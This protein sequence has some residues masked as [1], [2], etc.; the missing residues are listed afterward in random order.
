[1]TL[2]NRMQVVN[3][4][5][6]KQKPAEMLSFKSPFVIANNENMYTGNRMRENNQT[7]VSK[8]N[9][10]SKTRKVLNEMLGK[11]GPQSTKHSNNMHVTIRT[12]FTSNNKDTRTLDSIPLKKSPSLKKYERDTYNRADTRERPPSKERERSTSN[13][14]KKT[15]LSMTLECRKGEAHSRGNTIMAGLNIPPQS[16]L[17][18]TQ[19]SYGTSSLAQGQKSVKSNK[20]LISLCNN[21]NVKQVANKYN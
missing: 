9:S 14:C 11:M 2:D 5:W 19:L 6:C 17:D 10:T 8:S 3:N 21:R 7:G 20:K 13:S 12:N 18:S 1:M 4:H 15:N 16:F